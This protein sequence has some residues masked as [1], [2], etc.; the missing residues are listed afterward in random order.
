MKNH[1]AFL[2]FLIIATSQTHAMEAFSY[3]PTIFENFKLINEMACA[4]S[5]YNAAVNNQSSR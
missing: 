4:L 2:L 1:N 3:T 5:Q